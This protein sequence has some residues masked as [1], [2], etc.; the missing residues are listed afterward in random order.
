MSKSSKKTKEKLM[1]EEE[2][3]KLESLS[4]VL[5]DLE[6][7]LNDTCNPEEIAQQIESIKNK[8]NIRKPIEIVSSK[9]Q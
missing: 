3:S 9:G 7:E 5:D 6:C 1:R 8:I 2:L 4:I